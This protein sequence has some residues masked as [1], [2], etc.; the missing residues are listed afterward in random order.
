MCGIIVSNA[1]RVLVENYLAHTRYRGPDA[2]SIIESQG[3]CFGFNRLAFQGSSQAAMQPMTLDD[4]WLIVFNGEIYNCGELLDA[5]AQAGESYSPKTNSDTEVLLAYLAFIVK[6][7]AWDAIRLIDGIFAYVLL[8]KNDST[9]YYGNDRFSVKPLFIVNDGERIHIVSDL[10]YFRNL[11]RKDHADSLRYVQV[12]FAVSPASLYSGTAP[13]VPGT[14]YKRKV[15]AVTSEAVFQIPQTYTHSSALRRFSPLNLKRRLV[16]AIRANLV[17]DYPGCCLLSGGVDS[18]LLTLIVNA[19]YKTKPAV[20]YS[21]FFRDDPKG[22]S[23]WCKKFL[24]KYPQVVN[25]EFLITPEVFVDALAEYVGKTRRLPVIPNEIAMFLLFKRI[26]S[27]GYRMAL[28][29]EGADELFDG[30][31]Y[32]RDAAITNLLRA[33]CLGRH[34]ELLAKLLHHRWPRF[35]AYLRSPGTL[36]QSVATDSEGYFNSV[37]YYDLERI[38]RI[39]VARYLPALLSRADSASM[40]NSVELRVPFLSNRVFDEFFARPSDIL[41]VIFPPK[42]IPKVLLSFYTDIQYAFSSKRGFSVP[43]QAWY[44]TSPEFRGMCARAQKYALSVPALRSFSAK[45][46][47]ETFASYFER[48]GFRLLSLY[49]YHTAGKPEPT[50]AA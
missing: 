16:E 42:V 9:I 18:S 41:A 38:K 20:T 23:Y 48:T 39:M 32:I 11:E 46:D 17:G 50:V 43:W 19:L 5:M 21:V 2:T 25:R 14:M 1:G 34:T 30:Y 26:S 28:C 33:A 4:R 7:R 31:H 29:G 8:D 36:L 47:T 40:A 3:Y 12:P 24:A 27:D 44:D 35:A 10:S 45:S 37:G 13:V 22:E 49:L 15:N 6:R